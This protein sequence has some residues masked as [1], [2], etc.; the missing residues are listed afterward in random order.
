MPHFQQSVV[1]K[2]KTPSIAGFYSGS[3]HPSTQHEHSDSLS[4][5]P[6][7]THHI[8]TDQIEPLSDISCVPL[9]EIEKLTLSEDVTHHDRIGE[10][11]QLEIG[12]QDST[13]LEANS[14]K[15]TQAKSV[16]FDI[17]VSEEEEKEREVVGTIESL[18]RNRDTVM[19]RNCDRE[20]CWNDNDDDSWI[21]PSN[22][23]QAC[24]KMGGALESKP[25][26]I[27]VGCITTDYAMQVHSRN[28]TRIL[29]CTVLDYQCSL[30]QNTSVHCT[31]L[32]VFTVLDYQCSLYQITSVH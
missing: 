12:G 8:D 23:K 10:N 4:S 20:E 18:E 9:D 30:Y 7:E 3:F 25:N 14:C 27:A 15:E 21:T 1:E 13:Y 28:G 11:D 22:Y 2:P 29:V 19:E 17:A 32:L 26:G 6:A 5:S 31:R 24:E 16:T